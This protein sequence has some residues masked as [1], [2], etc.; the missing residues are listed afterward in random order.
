MHRI[1]WLTVVAV[2]WAVPVS[3]QSN[4]SV[5]AGAADGT[6][7]NIQL[8]VAARAN[9]TGALYG[10]AK[11]GAFLS[12]GACS[13]SW[14]QS[15]RCSY[16]G[17]S[18]EIGVE[19]IPV[20]T[21]RWFA[22]AS[23]AAGVWHRNSPPPDPTSLTWTAGLAGGVRVRDRVWLEL[24]YERRWIKDSEFEKL[25]DEYPNSNAVTVGLGLQL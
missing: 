2:L 16:T 19:L 9:V 8:G 1:D 13:Q 24:N 14:P 18:A 22:G 17:R 3:A 10:T 6:V 7:S 15:F 25:F 4:L 20:R 23:A 12:R 21:E 5:R 11:L